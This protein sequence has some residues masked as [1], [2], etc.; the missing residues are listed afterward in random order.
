[1]T[2]PRG[3]AWPVIL[4]LLLAPLIAEVLWGTTTVTNPAAY[5]IQI[6]LY[7]GGA[8]LIREVVRRWGGG[9]PSILLLGAA[10][11]AIEEGLL[12]P[13]WFT[14]ALQTHPY[15]VAARRVLDL[16]RAEHR[17]PRRLQHRDPDRAHRAGVP[18]LAEQA[19]ARPGRDVRAAHPLARAR[20]GCTP[21]SK[22]QPFPWSSP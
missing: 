3:R 4:L 8:V 5:L 16:R 12:E 20:P 10:Y 15:G 7:G 19:L 13:N 2:M 14:P 1:M 22:A 6:G 21:F 11:G 18:R 17:L 9:W